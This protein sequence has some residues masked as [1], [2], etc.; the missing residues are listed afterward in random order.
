MTQ[1]AAEAKIIEKNLSQGGV[2]APDALPMPPNIIRAWHNFLLCLLALP[3]NDMSAALTYAQRCEKLIVQSHRD[4]MMNPV[5]KQ[6]PDTETLLPNVLMTFIVDRVLSDFCGAQ[7]NLVDS[8][9][10]YFNQ[11]VSQ[12][13]RLA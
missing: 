9:W 7:P 12:N 1:I 11:L 3:A 10:E 8:Y 4:L 2:S 6:L 5:A 13:S